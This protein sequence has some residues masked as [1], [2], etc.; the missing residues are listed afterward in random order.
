[1][2]DLDALVEFEQGERTYTQLWRTAFSE[3]YAIGWKQAADTGFHDHGRL[4]RLVHVVRGTVAEEHIVLRPNGDWLARVEF[5]AGETFRFDGAHIHR[6]RH[7]AGEIALTVHVYSPPL[8]RAGAYELSADGTLR[9]TASRATRSCA[10]AT[11]SRS[12]AASRIPRRPTM[13]APG[14]R[15]SQPRSRNSTHT[16]GSPLSSLHTR[17]SAAPAGSAGSRR[18]SSSLSARA[19]GSREP[20]SAAQGVGAEGIDDVEA[21]ER[22]RLEGG[23]VLPRRVGRELAHALRGVG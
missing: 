4:R 1:M 5:A 19:C 2:Y 10:R 9:R 17:I 7:A 12:A 15:P 21:P 11:R 18:A 14:H 3:A 8:G 6:M 20:A 13:L 16:P 23:V 22:E